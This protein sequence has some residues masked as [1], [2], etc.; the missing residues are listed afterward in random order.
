MIHLGRGDPPRFLASLR[1]RI[2]SGLL[3]ARLE[4]L[5]RP[6]IG[7]RYA[8]APLG[9]CISFSLVQQTSILH[10]SSSRIRG[11]QPPPRPAEEPRP[12]AACFNDVDLGG[13]DRP[14]FSISLLFCIFPPLSPASALGGVEDSLTETLSTEDS[15]VGRFFVGH[16]AAT[17]FI[18]FSKLGLPWEIRGRL[19]RAR[20]MPCRPI[21][22]QPFPGRPSGRLSSPNFL[23]YRRS[24][25]VLG[26]MS[27]PWVSRRC[28]IGFYFLS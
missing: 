9:S 10:A 1:H 24:S 21:L 2:R 23:Y 12:S 28:I 22:F 8:R 17:T 27:F 25:I 19:F 14:K 15:V 20:E 7:L 3:I 26:L 5:G 18:S 11:S 16:F 13:A 4:L 6:P